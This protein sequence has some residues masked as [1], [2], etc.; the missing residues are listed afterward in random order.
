[1]NLIFQISIQ[2]FNF[3][4]KVLP[5][6]SVILLQVYLAYLWHGRNTLRQNEKNYLKTLVYL[7]KQKQYVDYNILFELRELI[8][9]RYYVRQFGQHCLTISGYQKIA[10]CIT[11]YNIDPLVVKVAIIKNKNGQLMLNKILMYIAIIAYTGI[12]LLLL[13]LFIDLIHLP[14]NFYGTRAYI[15][16]SAVI[17]IVAVMQ[18]FAVQFALIGDALR[19]IPQLLDNIPL[20]CLDIS[21]NPPLFFN[22]K[23]FIFLILT[24]LT[25][26]ISY[27]LVYL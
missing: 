5:Y 27:R 2:V 23:E 25:L 19:K 20:D 15:S 24:M 26:S 21:K 11:Q 14:K 8:T 22:T 1:M 13:N 3:I 7:D 6:I 12:A 17:L 9:Y 4:E 10:E 16:W 18:Y